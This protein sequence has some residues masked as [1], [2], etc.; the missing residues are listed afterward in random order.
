MPS[1]PPGRPMSPNTP[2]RRP[3]HERSHSQS[4]EQ[5]FPT[6]VRLIQD[7]DPQDE[8]NVY[9]ATPYPTKPEHV[10]LP[11][12]ST[13]QAPPYDQEYNVSESTPDP[14]ISSSSS[15]RRDYNLSY[16][17]Q[18]DFSE[19]A[20]TFHGT[21][22]S[23]RTWD[24]TPNSSKTS[25]PGSTTPQTLRHERRG[26]GERDDNSS[27]SDGMPLP[28]T[29]KPVPQES[30]SPQ[31]T[32]PRESAYYESVSGVSG[33]GSSPNVVPLGLTSSPNFVPLDTSSPNLVP[34][35]SSSPNLAPVSATDSSLYEANSVGTARRYIRAGQRNSTFTADGS[36]SGQQDSTPSHSIPSSPP[37]AV[38]RSY[39][40][41]SSFGLPPST[42]F[43]VHPSTSSTSSRSSRSAPDVRSTYQSS[44]SVQYPTIR[45]PSTSSRPE[46]AVSR[47]LQP[48]VQSMTE[49]FSGGWNPHLSTVPS[50]WSAERLQ[51]PGSPPPRGGRRERS[52]TQNTEESRARDSSG[53]SI[54]PVDENESEEHGDNLS[55]LRSH[56][57]APLRNKT[58]RSLS[59]KSSLSSLSRSRSR[60]FLRPTS[61]S[62]SVLSVIPS[63]AR[64]YY[65]TGGLDIQFASSL[66]TVDSRPSTPASPSLSAISAL[67]AAYNNDQLVSRTPLGISNPR[68]RPREISYPP[69][70]SAPSPPSISDPV[71]PRTHWV[72][73]PEMEQVEPET[74]LEDLPGAWSPHL[75]PDK[76]ADPVRRSVWNPPSLD[77][78]AEGCCGRRNLQIYAFVLGFVFPLAWIIAS[79]LP[80]PPRVNQINQDATTS[81]PDVE[82]AF[83]NRVVL[84]DEARYE[85]ARWWRN[86]NR[87]MSPIGVA[88]IV[89]VVS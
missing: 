13:N 75:H 14:T 43:R 2:K 53:P 32:S 41:T 47:P 86:V 71:D 10:L 35:G 15:V 56:Q 74:P 55:H 52:L 30:S 80:L 6:T 58:S 78:K 25:I 57:S 5:S 51:S 61:S 33:D 39:Q 89:V 54:L 12:S 46:T 40:S 9:S 62:S 50:E 18:R 81:R 68:V 16:H 4:N 72:P 1:P 84:I 21:A 23:S 34:L 36:S 63:W 88:I 27:G 19:Q 49:R 7:Q 45:Q 79:F 38:L 59:Q 77:E 73:D 48:F 65:R 60:S 85:S 37:V 66:F 24:D 64:A 28:S 70:P 31:T 87:W 69:R 20:S 26:D 17:D 83:H 44:T 82:Q 3:L 22:S 76:R 8:T 42:A 29:I 11:P 67:S